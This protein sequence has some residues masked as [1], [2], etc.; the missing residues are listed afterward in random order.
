MPVHSGSNSNPPISHYEAAGELAVAEM[1]GNER[2]AQSMGST[3]KP[4]VQQEMA[5]LMA[6]QAKLDARRTR[7]MEL[8]DLDEEEQRIRTRMQVLGQAQR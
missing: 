7:L 8:A 1:P 5:H 4:Q 6:E 3:D 2:L